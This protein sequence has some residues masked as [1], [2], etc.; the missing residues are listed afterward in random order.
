M[1]VD[2]AVIRYL[3]NKYGIELK[4]VGGYKF[5]LINETGFKRNDNGRICALGLQREKKLDVHFSD[6]FRELEYLEDLNLDFNS[7]TDLGFLATIPQLKSL[8]IRENLGINDYTPISGLTELT[9]LTLSGKNIKNLDFLAGLQKLET[10]WLKDISATDLSPIAGLERLDTL[11]LEDTQIEDISVFEGLD[12]LRRL[13]FHSDR[14]TNINA[15]KHLT[16][17]RELILKGALIKD[18][19]VLG[20]FSSLQEL[21]I[22]RTAVSDVSALQSLANL[23]SIALINNAIEEL[24]SWIFSLNVYEDIPV[25]WTDTPMKYGFAIM[26][27]NLKRPPMNI[28][29]GGLSTIKD[30]FK[31]I[32]QGSGETQKLYEAKLLVIGQGG[33]GKTSFVRKV[34]DAHAKMPEQQD[35]T[36]GIDIGS[37]RFEIE[38]QAGK[39]SLFRVNFWDF[40]GQKIYQGT[41]QIF[42]TDK[43]FYVLL[44]DTR[45]EKTD[46]SYWLNTVEQLGGDGSM[47]AIVI[48]EM[49]GR[50][51]KFDEP[52]YRGHFGKLIKNVSALDL[53]NDVPKIKQLQNEIKMHLAELPGIGDEL[54]SEWVAIREHLLSID[55][56]FIS[57]DAFREIC[58]DHGVR[59][60][61]MMARLSDYF[62]RIGVFT[63]FID[64]A[65][66]QERI[67]L[68]S[69]WLVK[70]VY[71]VLD[72]PTA[73]D[74]KGRI[75]DE[76]IRKI[77]GRSDLQYEANKLSRLMHKFGLMYHIRGKDSYVIPEHL[78]TVMP[79]EKWPYHDQKDI[80]QFIY[81]FDQYMPRG[82]MSRLIVALHHHIDDHDLVWHRGFNIQSNGAHAE[83]V[84][85]YG[86]SNQF[87]IRITGKNKIELLSIIRER[88]AE[89]LAPFHR[90]KYIQYV[91]CI[92]N[93]CKASDKPAFHDYN[94]LLK[95][96]ANGNG[97][98]C[99]ATGDTIPAELLLKMMEY[100]K[101]EEGKPGTN[102]RLFLASSRE[103]Q[104]EREAFR[105]FISVENDIS[106][107]N[108]NPE[109]RV[110][111]EIVQW[112]FFLDEIS[113]NGKQA[114]YNDKIRE[115]DMAVCLFF[116]EAGRY[117]E[118]EFDTAYDHFKAYTKPRIWT[119]FKNALINTA[120]ITANI[121]SLLRFKE[122]LKSLEHYYTSYTSTPDLHLK[123]KRQLDAFVKEHRDNQKKV[124]EKD[125]EA[126]KD[127]SSQDGQ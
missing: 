83:I 41:H 9:I 120:D 38:E 85:S 89:V 3:Q 21:Q 8:S 58:K 71:E 107:R 26:D 86:S 105:Q 102:L 14:I 93:Y 60:N 56:N 82:I 30:Y 124:I 72:N 75:S 55:K 44:A 23:R 39:K 118:A 32:E 7:L 28:I 47:V 114:E 15:L 4:S 45:E 125:P 37:W 63:H 5:E 106:Q 22:K 94:R 109:D 12:S 110:Y 34:Q 81:E 19:G 31:Q 62:N 98:Q 99:N 17:L 79:Y 127:P 78:P 11:I 18:I 33:S 27:D 49:Y 46:F 57:F 61:G 112:E 59:E 54:P 48:N 90:L 116:T 74:R 66:L 123:F 113:E 35:T 80:L 84:E 50:E 104:Q 10:L 51:S 40:G 20:D 1:T 119:Y 42:F 96:R 73:I 16:N 67:Y 43:S 117:T 36:F 13:K 108:E 70:I 53:S 24:P 69:N 100:P 103:L 91:P 52:G 122:K 25:S 2:E 29:R 126:K 68:N 87:L 95:F 64:D 77:W 115:S 92:C 101:R 65:L 76:D 111:V 121:N 88:F 97:S 6:F